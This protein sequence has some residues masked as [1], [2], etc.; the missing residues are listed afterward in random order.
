[1]S[2]IY[3]SKVEFRETIGLSEY[4]SG[5]I[6]LLNIVDRELSYQRYKVKQTGASLI[7]G[8]VSHEFNGKHYTIPYSKNR[9]LSAKN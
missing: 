9:F 3:F 4:S 2:Q 1:M 7:V 6:M 8:E 5:S